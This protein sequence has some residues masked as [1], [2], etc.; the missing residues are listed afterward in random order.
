MLFRSGTVAS[1]TNPSGTWDWG[2][3]YAR[4]LASKG[5]WSKVTPHVNINLEK[6]TGF[7]RTLAAFG[8]VGYDLT[9]RFAVDV[10]GQRF[11]LTGGGQDRQLLVS[12][13]LNLGKMR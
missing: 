8:G 3:G 2:G 12:F 9:D 4:Q 5:V 7:E 10:S 13:T 6:S 1:D 11:G